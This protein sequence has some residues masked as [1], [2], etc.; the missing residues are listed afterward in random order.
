MVLNL[1]IPRH[2]LCVA[3]RWSAAIARPGLGGRAL[4]LGLVVV[5]LLGRRRVAGA[6]V[7]VALRLGRLR[8]SGLLRLVALCLLPVAAAVAVRAVDEHV[9]AP[10]LGVLRDALV[11]VVVGGFGVLG[12]DVP[13]VE[14]AGD[15]R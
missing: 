6:V 9:D 4:F 15:L 5:L 13:G 1:M 10:V 12:D 14:K 3:R 7:H 8:V 2:N 11:V